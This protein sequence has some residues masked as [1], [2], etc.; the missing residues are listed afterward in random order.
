MTGIKVADSLECLVNNTVA[1]DLTDHISFL[2]GLILHNILFF[3][4]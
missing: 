1:S 2:H 3:F 4:L